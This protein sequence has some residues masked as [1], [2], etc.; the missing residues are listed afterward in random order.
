[1]G[2][3]FLSHVAEDFGVVKEIAAGLEHRGFT[4]WYYEEHA[5][6][7]MDHMT[8][9]RE[10][11]EQ[12]DVVAVVISPR[13]LADQRY[14]WPEV[15]R[16]VISRKRFLPL[17]LAVPWETVERDYP[18]WDDALGGAVAIPVSPEG[19]SEILPRIIAGLE[20]WGILPTGPRPSPT[21]ASEAAA[22]PSALA[23]VEV[24]EA[25][26]TALEVD[27]IASSADTGLGGALADVIARV[28]G[29]VTLEERDRKAPIDLGEAVETTGGD[30]PARWVIHAATIPPSAEIIRAATRSTLRKADELGARSI[31]LPAFG[32]GGGGFPL[33]E[34]ARIEAE[35]VRRH[36]DDGSRLQTIVFAVLGR[37]AREAFQLAVAGLNL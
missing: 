28:A 24:R 31:A 6:P 12:A 14:V 21:A 7:G 5:L 19:P 37:D 23:K 27:A 1:M 8:Q 25:D 16:A 15:R 22:E 9:T 3:V 2:Q 17:L 20:R 11:I 13:S 32:T 34:A 33:R 29:R 30:L 35:E 36:L 10:A 18:A 26:I 4:T